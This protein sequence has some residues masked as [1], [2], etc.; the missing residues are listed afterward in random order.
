[1]DATV[2]WKDGLAFEGIADTGFAVA[3]DAAPD[4]GG[5]N[6]GFRPLELMLV[7]LGGCTA[8][9]VISILKKMRQD[10]TGFEVRVSGDRATDH[11]KVFTRL[12]IDMLLL[13]AG[14]TQRRWKR[15]S[16]CQ[17]RAIARPR[18]C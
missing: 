14:S 5:Q 1:M 13:A 4:A 7:S 16:T 15:P 6:T 11:P 17:P 9:D 8:M 18:P 12:R 10:V 2:T 3:L